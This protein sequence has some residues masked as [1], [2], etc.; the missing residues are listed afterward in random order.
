MR[1]EFISDYRSPYSYLANLKL[2]TLGVSI[3]HKPLDIVAVMKL[4][5]NQP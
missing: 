4:V 1:L 3:E 5:N 2:K